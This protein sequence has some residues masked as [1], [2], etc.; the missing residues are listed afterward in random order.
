MKGKHYSSDILNGLK[1]CVSIEQQ[2][3]YTSVNKLQ[4]SFPFSQLIQLIKR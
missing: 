4:G 2:T 3:L 1:H